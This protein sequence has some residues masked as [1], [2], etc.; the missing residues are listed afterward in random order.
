MDHFRIEIALKIIGLSL[1]ETLDLFV[2]VSSKK[3]VILQSSLN[4]KR[5]RSVL[6]SLRCFIFLQ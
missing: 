6:K 5:P 1:N 2:I 3:F 4:S